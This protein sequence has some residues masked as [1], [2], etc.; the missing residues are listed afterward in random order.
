MVM[1]CIF[2]IV[3][4]KV[5]HYAPNSDSIL[6]LEMAKQYSHLNFF[7]P[8]TNCVGRPLY[9]IFL[10]IIGNILSYN[11]YVICL[12]QSILFC[13][14]ALSLTKELE[15]LLQKNLT[16]MVLILFL[17]P[18]IQASNG[19]ILTEAL[20]FS[21]VLFIFSSALKILSSYIFNSSVKLAS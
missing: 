13:I 8:F 10:A 5:Y 18:E 19:T 15:I 6:Y 4:L 17:V 21:L 9:P 14:A 1:H 11:Y 3:N 7:D 16:A 20:A 2:T 12:A